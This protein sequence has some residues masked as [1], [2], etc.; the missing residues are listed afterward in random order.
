MK[1]KQLAKLIKKN[2]AK[3]EK[4]QTKK[5]KI[6]DPTLKATQR[7]DAEQSDADDVERTAFFKEM[8]RREF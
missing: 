3:V 5:S 4:A 8:K 2:V 1:D 6:Y 7:P